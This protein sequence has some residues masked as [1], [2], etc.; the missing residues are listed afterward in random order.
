MFSANKNL[1]FFD[2]SI[3][4]PHDLLRK[5]FKSENVRLSMF[6]KVCLNQF[7][8]FFIVTDPPLEKVVTFS[9]EAS[10]L[11]SE[12]GLFS[13]FFC[14][15]Q[16]LEVICKTTTPSQSWIKNFYALGKSK[17]NAP[18]FLSGN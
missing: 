8:E 5:N 10:L 2:F 3:L 12:K 16:Q 7:F 4:S 11:L 14:F 6:Y 17:T 13:Y 1:H 9:A 15:T 18:F